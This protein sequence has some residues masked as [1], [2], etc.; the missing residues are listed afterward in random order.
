MVALV[1]GRTHTLSSRVGHLALWAAY[2]LGIVRFV[3]PLSSVAQ[4]RNKEA[5][6]EV[7]YFMH[8]VKT[9]GS[10]LGVMLSMSFEPSRVCIGVHRQQDI[11]NPYADPFLHV[12][13][14]G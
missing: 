10:S 13:D 1:F 4:G 9:A 12:G 14:P 5:Q 8:L 3:L 2:T 7:F 11:S 6:H